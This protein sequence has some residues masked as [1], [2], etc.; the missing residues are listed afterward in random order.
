MTHET[1]PFFDEYLGNVTRFI[2]GTWVTT[3]GDLQQ[4]IRE[5]EISVRDKRQAPKMQQKLREDMKRFGL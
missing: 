1:R 2:E 4:G 5:H 3:I